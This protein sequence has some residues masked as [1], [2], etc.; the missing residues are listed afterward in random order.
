MAVA[1]E[2]LSDSETSSWFEKLGINNLLVTSVSIELEIPLPS[3][4]IT[5]IP[6][7]VSF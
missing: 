1:V 7:G 2:T 6:E 5:T 3:L 4:P